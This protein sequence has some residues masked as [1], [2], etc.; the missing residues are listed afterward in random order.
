MKEPV[1]GHTYMSQN[2]QIRVTYFYKKLKSF[3][4]DYAGL[5]RINRIDMIYELRS[6]DWWQVAY[7]MVWA[8]T[9]SATCI[10]SSISRVRIT[11]LGED[12]Y[13]GGT[14]TAQSEIEDWLGNI[15][16]SSTYTDTANVTIWQ[17]TDTPTSTQDSIQKAISGYPVLSISSSAITNSWTY[18]GYAR[19]VI[20]TDGRTNTTFTVYNDLGQVSYTQSSTNKTYYFCNNLGQRTMVAN[21]L[22]QVDHTAYNSQGQ[23]IATWGTS[24]PVAYEFNTAGRMIAMA[25]TRSNEYANVNLNTLLTDE[26]TLNDCNVQGLDITQWQYDEATGLL[27][28]KLYADGNGTSYTYTETGKIQT[29]TYARGKTTTYVYNNLGQLTDIDYSDST[30]DVTFTHDRLSRIISASSSTSAR[31]FHYDGLTLDY[32]TQNGYIID[33]KQDTFGRNTGHVLTGGSLSPMTLVYVFD[34]YGRFYSVESAHSAS[35]NL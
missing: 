16:R 18:D 8:E 10:T 3:Y 20:A 21:A 33:R 7:N 14:L 9:N 5:D 32:E 29:R 25:T 4:F 34:E 2:Y 35:T 26:E 6:N 11:G 24:Y 13:N 17:V 15:T 23:A 30:P 12:T 1:K 22:Y 28:N 27:T 31:T 19:Q